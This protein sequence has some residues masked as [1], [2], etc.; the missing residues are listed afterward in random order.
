[1][2]AGRQQWP[3]PAKR[4]CRGVHRRP[5]QL[6]KR[7]APPARSSSSTPPRPRLFAS[8]GRRAVP[9]TSRATNLGAP[10]NEKRCGSQPT[11]GSESKPS[12]PQ[13]KGGLH[14]GETAL[15]SSWRDSP[16]VLT[17]TQR[18]TDTPQSTVVESSATKAEW[19]AASVRCAAAVHEQSATAAA[20]ATTPAICCGNMGLAALP[21]RDRCASGAHFPR[22]RNATFH[23]SLCG[24]KTRAANGAFCRGPKRHPGG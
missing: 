7:R 19:C 3:T 6:A 16:R 12:S 1:M 15:R 4:C 5:G 22:R 13:G 23:A 17:C 18:R 14:A 10:R 20:K 2:L 21:P 11:G 9:A 24:G 8:T